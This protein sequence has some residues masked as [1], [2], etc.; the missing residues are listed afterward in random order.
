MPPAVCATELAPADSPDVQL[1][2]RLRQAVARVRAAGSVSD[3][4]PLAAAELTGFAGCEG[5]ALLRVD[6]DEAA[7]QAL[8]CAA[9]G[10]VTGPALQRP[11][12]SLDR[13]PVESAI[14]R[15]TR[16]EFT[17]GEVIGVAA[18][19]RQPWAVGDLY[20]AVAP[21]PAGGRTIGL[22]IGV[23]TAPAPAPRAA[24]LEAVWA[25][26]DALGAV[27][28]NVWMLERV[29]LQLA[30]VRPL[31]MAVGAVLAEI[32]DTAISL[33]PASAETP[34]SAMPSPSSGG[35]GE[36]SGTL[37]DL[38]LT[39]RELGVLQLM[40]DGATNDRIAETLMISATTVKS[41]VRTI[42]RKLHASNRAEAAS[43]FAAR[44]RR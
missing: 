7:L 21:I 10:D 27:V 38:G 34:P 30:H 1:L 19:G 25:F 39:A 20:C 11:P 8:H 3:L 9:R 35:H 15:R 28:E 16:A 40:A 22:A 33:A 36:I 13:F 37:D 44:R 42:L 43:L 41:H 23:W 5:A 31:L 26:A 18:A 29:R 12:F 24:E 2:R 6:G 32:S 17:G 4:L 14:I